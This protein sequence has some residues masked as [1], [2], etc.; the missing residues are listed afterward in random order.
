[1]AQSCLRTTVPTD[2]VLTSQLLQ[3]L[4]PVMRGIWCCHPL[5]C[6]PILVNLSSAYNF[7]RCM[8][9][10]VP[11][12]ENFSPFPTVTPKVES[13]LPITLL[14][15]KPYFLRITRETSIIIG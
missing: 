3:I 15:T 2:Q 5:L 13:V 12:M 11:R 1:M 14:I 7:R 10:L 9:D 6:K 4:M 8:G